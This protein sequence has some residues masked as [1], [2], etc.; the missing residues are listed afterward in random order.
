MSHSPLREPR[1]VVRTHK[2][3]V[4][5]AAPR[6]PASP[7]SSRRQAT[8]AAPQP[9][10]AA[11][12]PPPHLPGTTRRVAN[13]C[14]ATADAINRKRPEGWGRCGGWRRLLGS[15]FTRWK[16]VLG[17]T[18][19][20]RRQVRLKRSRLLDF[21]MPFVRI[22]FSEVSPSSERVPLFSVKWTVLE[23]FAGFFKGIVLLHYFSHA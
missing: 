11:R 2:R 19:H 3:S 16:R 17:V 7:R 1:C 14:I 18:R 12:C 6:P 23:R 10:S 5:R 21:L 9:R 20:L 22:V 8:T 4:L 13:L 15:P